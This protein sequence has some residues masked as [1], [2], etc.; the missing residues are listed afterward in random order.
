MLG[1]WDVEQIHTLQ[2]GHFPTLS[3]PKLL[4]ELML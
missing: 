4:A 1:N 2:S 3:V